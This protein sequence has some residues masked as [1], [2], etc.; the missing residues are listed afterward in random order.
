MSW[1]AWSLTSTLLGWLVL[2]ASFLLTKAFSTDQWEVLIP[3]TVHLFGF[4]VLAAA[5]L[6]SLLWMVSLGRWQ[7]DMLVALIN[8]AL[9][10]GPLG[11]LVWSFSQQN[12]P[13]GKFLFYLMWTGK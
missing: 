2:A 7:E 4:L 1:R 12:R 10:L 3:L 8:L 5:C 11:I 13:F 9:A 6:L